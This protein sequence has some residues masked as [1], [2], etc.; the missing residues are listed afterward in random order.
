MRRVEQA[1]L[2]ETFHSLRTLS[3]SS[4]LRPGLRAFLRAH[5]EAWPYPK[6]GLRQSASTCRS[7][8]HA[9]AA[10]SSLRASGRHSGV[11]LHRDHS[12]TLVGVNFGV[13]TLVCAD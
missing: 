8:P 5:P 6:I 2:I 9:D 12:G 3:T 10:A 11:R 1:R 4:R 7:L 13:L